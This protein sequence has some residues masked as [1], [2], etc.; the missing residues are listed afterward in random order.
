[1]TA[2]SLLLVVSAYL[3]GSLMGALIVNRLFQVADP[4][5]SGS[6]N[7]GASN[8][9]RNYGKWAGFLTLFIDVIKGIVPVATALFLQQPEWVLGVTGVAAL[10][11]HIFPLYYGFSG[12][13]GVATALGI[14]SVFSLKIAS[15]LLCIWIVIFALSRYS[16]LASL[17]AT[18]AAPILTYYFVPT[19]FVPV[20]VM[21]FFIFL[22]HKDNVNRLCRGKEFRFSVK[23]TKKTSN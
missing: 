20:I 7:P 19:F 4:R 2:L 16:S 13:K 18:L 15:G 22:K 23:E 6:G 14:F 8:M 1:M 5:Q 17:S 9:L 11:G 21:S 3:I 10:L 12:G